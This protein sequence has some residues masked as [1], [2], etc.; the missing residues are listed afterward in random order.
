MKVW[1]LTAECGGAE[2]WRALET[3]G[4]DCHRMLL[5]RRHV[6]SC[7][8]FYFGSQ[9]RKPFLSDVLPQLPSI[10]FKKRVENL[11]FRSNVA[12]LVSRDLVFRPLF[13]PSDF[14]ASG[15]ECLS[16][17]TLPCGVLGGCWATRGPNGS[18][19]G[20]DN[21]NITKSSVAATIP[22]VWFQKR[23]GRLGHD[24]K[25]R[26]APLHCF[27]E[28]QHW[29]TKAHPLS[30][31]VQCYCCKATRGDCEDCGSA[32]A[33]NIFEPRRNDIVGFLSFPVT[34]VAIEIG[35]S[36]ILLGLH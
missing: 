15:H 20:F 7:Y 25:V 18:L 23:W 32:I 22:W 14:P 8:I 34:R 13:K 26:L 12:I 28:F 2:A 30:A 9:S 6:I 3:R 1:Q 35:V 29:A 10:Q 17:A 27:Q 11:W 33:S 36:G 4:W 21:L 5:Q 24:A 19:G 16:G 31:G